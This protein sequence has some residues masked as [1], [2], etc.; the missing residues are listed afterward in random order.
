M[1]SLIINCYYVQFVSVTTK[2]LSNGCDHNRVADYFLESI[3]NTKCRFLAVQC[4]SYDDF[5]KG[6]CLP[7]NSTIAEMGFHSTKIEGIPL[8]SKFFLRTNG[9]APF[10]IEDSI[11]LWSWRMLILP[12]MCIWGWQINSFGRRSFPPIMI[13]TH[14]RIVQSIIHWPLL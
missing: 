3:D 4:Q 1:S 6:N 14:F 5:E 7:E 8:Q 10:C 2:W 9:T 13:L 11:H 12:R